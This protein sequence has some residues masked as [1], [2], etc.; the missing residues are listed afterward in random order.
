MN[1]DDYRDE[2]G[3]IY[4]AFDVVRGMVFGAVAGIVLIVLAWWIA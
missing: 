1:S 4:V 3:L 2:A